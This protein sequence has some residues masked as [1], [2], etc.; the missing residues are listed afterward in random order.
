M[1]ITLEAQLQVIERQVVKLETLQ[2]VNT[3]AVTEM[4]AN[5][6]RLIDKLDKSDDTAKEAAQR[7]RSAH[8]RIDELREAVD[9]IKQGQRWL[10]T[11]SF[12]L[13]GLAAS[14]LGLVIK[15]IQ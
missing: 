11:T 10:I 7:A 13:I 14:L 3:R 9:G 8:H 15:F 5:I 4:A 1:S 2:E 12:G 6:S